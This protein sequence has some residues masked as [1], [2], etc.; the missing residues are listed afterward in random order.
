MGITEPV[1]GPAPWVNPV[2]IVPKNNGEIR[3]CVDMRQANQAIMRRRYP[4][5]TIDEVLHTMNGFKVFSKLDLKWGYQQNLELSPESR[6]ITTFVTPDGLFQYKRLLFGVCSASEQNQH[7]IASA[8][9]G[10]EGVENISD[11]IVVHGPDTE[12]HNRRLHL[13]IEGL[14]E[15]GLNLMLRKVCSIRTG[16]CS[17]VCSF[18]RKALILQQIVSK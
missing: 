10:I 4:I 7:E 16:W 3:L 15:C 12:T 2:V 6:E 1:E 14:L 18:Q 9:T 11:D 5:P 8:L 17:W 13:T